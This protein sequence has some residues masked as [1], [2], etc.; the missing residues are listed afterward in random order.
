[1]RKESEWMGLD[2]SAYPPEEILRKERES[3]VEERDEKKG[4]DITVGEGLYEREGEINDVRKRMKYEREKEKYGRICPGAFEMVSLQ[5]KLPPVMSKKQVNGCDIYFSL[6]FSTKWQYLWI[7]FL[8]RRKQFKSKSWTPS[9]V[10]LTMSA[11]WLGLVK[12]KGN[13]E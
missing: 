4:E 5:T 1:M 8:F 12:E 9:C 6:Q 13:G 10:R 11:A 7:W 2:V 3:A